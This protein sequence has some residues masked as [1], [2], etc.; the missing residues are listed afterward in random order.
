MVQALSRVKVD[1]AIQR[2]NTLE[3]YS[4]KAELCSEVVYEGCLRSGV[5]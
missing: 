4:L 5:S 2:R 1:Q 3:S